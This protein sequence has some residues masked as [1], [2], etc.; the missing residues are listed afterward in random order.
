MHLYLPLPCTRRPGKSG[1]LRSLGVIWKV[2]LYYILREPWRLS[3]V[4]T[5]L[6]GKKRARDVEDERQAS[7]EKVVVSMVE[8]EPQSM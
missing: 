2:Q 8:A 6:T 3:I 7:Q 5:Q 4:D 1:K